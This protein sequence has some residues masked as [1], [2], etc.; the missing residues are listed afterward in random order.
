MRSILASFLLACVMTDIARA[1]ADDETF[2]PA[3]LVMQSVQPKKDPTVFQINVKAIGASESSQSGEL[4]VDEKVADLTDKLKRLP[5][6]S[7]RLLS[8]SS[9][10]VSLL[11]R[12]TMKLSNGQ[13]LCVRPVDSSGD[14]ITLWLK[15]KARDGM[16]I[17]DTRV[18]FALNEA[19]VVGIEGQSEGTGTVLAISVTPKE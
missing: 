19:M 13:T 2:H 7:F 12:E 10:T 1:R 18:N 17:L 9:E 8:D 15:W 16:S 6:T 11:S 14:Q 5:F 3:S 4:E